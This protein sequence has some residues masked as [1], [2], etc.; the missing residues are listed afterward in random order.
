MRVTR[1]SSLSTLESAHRC[2][3]P[4]AVRRSAGTRRRPSVVADDGGALVALD[5]RKVGALGNVAGR[6]AQRRQRQQRAL[7]GEYATSHVA[8]L[9]RTILAYMIHTIVC[10]V[11]LSHRGCGVRREIH[12]KHRCGTVSS[13]AT[14]F[15]PRQT[16]RR[17]CRSKLALDRI[18]YRHTVRTR[19]PSTAVMMSPN[20]R[21]RRLHRRS[22]LTTATP[23][24]GGAGS[25]AGSPGSNPLGKAFA[26]RRLLCSRGMPNRSHWR[27]CQPSAF[28]G[29]CVSGEVSSRVPDCALRCP[30]CSAST[31]AGSPWP[32]REVDG[33]SYYFCRSASARMSRHAG[34]VAR[35]RGPQMA[36]QRRCCSAPSARTKE[37][38]PIWRSGTSSTTS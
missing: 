9:P 1:P 14:D 3:C 30:G 28:S 38:S 23:S 18:L 17:T 32:R 5:Q 24:F 16:T 29:G 2:P 12:G 25:H 11:R 27:E 13:N 35:S 36:R 10:S 7:Q 33:G 26:P 31:R 37:P 34:D 19:R 22:Q 15:P 6:T 20:L 8:L 4:P 21:P